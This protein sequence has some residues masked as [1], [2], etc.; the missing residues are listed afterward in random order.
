[1]S[2]WIPHS[3]VCMCVPV[4]LCSW[5]K[6]Y[7]WSRL[8]HRSRFQSNQ[9]HWKQLHTLFKSEQKT[10]FQMRISILENLTINMQCETISQ[11]QNPNTLKTDD[12]PRDSNSKSIQRKTDIDDNNNDNVDE[13]QSH[14]ISCIG[15]FQMR[16]LN[17]LNSMFR[18]KVT[19]KSMNNL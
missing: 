16:D 11:R 19:C 2:I 18:S 6:H 15:H 13:M 4:S 9:F 7:T 14:R 12:N 1:M 10:G 3:C 8:S 17:A 5:P